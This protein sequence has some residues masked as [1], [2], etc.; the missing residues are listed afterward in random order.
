MPSGAHLTGKPSRVYAGAMLLNG[1]DRELTAQEIG[2]GGFFSSLGNALKSGASQVFSAGLRVGESAA[3]KLVG[4]SPPAQVT[5]QGG[6]AGGGPQMMFA[7]SPDPAPAAGGLP[8]WALP[9]GL[10]AGA[11]VLVMLMRP[12]TAPNPRRRIRRHRRRRR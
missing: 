9:V 1:Y 5:I 11:L 7:P 2:L 12:K 4:A 10:G 6:G 3:Y 8:K